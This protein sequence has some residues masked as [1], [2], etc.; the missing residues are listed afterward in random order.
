MRR[1]FTIAGII[2]LALVCT[3]T[4]VQAENSR[5]QGS[6]KD[7]KTG[8]VLFGAN[9]LIVGTRMGATTDMMGKYTILDVPPGTYTVKASY[10]GYV[11]A[12]TV[13]TV[14]GNS[15]QCD[16]KLDAVGVI[17]EEV[18]ITAQAAGQNAAINQQLA[19]N[20]I[21][22]VVS[23]ARIQ[24]LPDANAAESVGRLPGVLVL[25]SGGEGNQVVVRG[26]QPKYNNILI[27]GV[28]MGSANPDDRS[29]DMSM[30][31]SQMLGGIEVSKT[32]TPDMDA[33]VLGG[34]VNFEMREAKVSQPGV[35]QIG[36]LAQG[37]YSNLPDAYN[38]YNNYKYIGSVE[39]RFLEDNLG[40]FVQVD[41]ERKNLSSN[42]L[43]ASYDHAGVSMTQYITNAL[44][45]HDIP[46]DRQRYNGALDIDYRLPEGKIK[47]TNLISSGTTNALDRNEAL[48]ITGNS[49]TYALGSSS[50][51]LTTL[52][53][54]LDFQQQLSI[55]QLDAKLSHAYSESKDP[56]DWT[57]TF[58][59]TSA[60]LN[61]FLNQPSLNPRAIPVAANYNIGTTYLNTFE[62][63]SDFSRERALTAS[64]DLKTDVSVSDLI[65]AE[66]KFGGKYR[67]Q[68]R[69]YNH[70]QYDGQPLI[71]GSATFL[72]KLI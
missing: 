60:G 49:L 40:V 23:A 61:Q 36:L 2:G 33:N 17:G 62:N 72:D 31:S 14:A 1:A 46:R 27:D 37:G 6:V 26:L 69:S 30:I 47:L 52:V 57:A 15:S 59:Q 21:V 42:E 67:H 29:T 51:T 70:D 48:T 38:K 39:D 28:Q 65:S 25:R 5:L 7:A 16:F 8:E 19:S 22:N 45:L 10:I 24:E 64:L 34:T 12:K 41:V 53:N 35:P 13:V 3:G 54:A 68:T 58:L 9:V 43:G 66:I 18:V 20:Q 32:V 11:E 71:S 44:N 50:S 4:T 63:T 55:F 56:R